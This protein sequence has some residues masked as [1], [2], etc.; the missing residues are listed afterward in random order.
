RPAKALSVAD[1]AD[2]ACAR[3]RVVEALKP[4]LG[5][6]VG[7]KAGL[8]AKPVQERFGASGPVAGVLL[9]GMILKDGADVPAAFGAR[10]VWEAD[11]LLVVRDEG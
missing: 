2:A 1:M 7:Y 9:E 10:G 8:T 6:A 3:D 11:M 4:G 5:G